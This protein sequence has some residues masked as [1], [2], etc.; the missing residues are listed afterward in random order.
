[1]QKDYKAGDFLKHEMSFATRTNDVPDGYISGIASSPS[2]DCYG[3]RVLPGAFDKSIRLRGFDGNKGGIKLLDHHDDKKPAIGVIRKLETV[4]KDL[5]I[6]AEFCLKS[7]R[8]KDMY[9]ETKFAGGMGFSVGF[10]LED[11]DFAEENGEDIF[12]IKEGDLREVSLVNFP[13]CSDA[14]MTF[15]KQ[16]AKLDDPALE[17]WLADMQ[18]AMLLLKDTDTV[19]ELEKALVAKGLAHGRNEAH[20]LFLVMKSCAHLLQDK[21]TPAGGDVKTA[22]PHPLLDASMLKPLLA[23]IARVQSML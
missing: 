12:L 1:M 8:V 15:I 7:S 4:G 20:K 10:R 23:D 9:E 19:S 22:P 6:E 3:H 5:R 14:Q 16:E 17:A 2:I 13:A 21:P 18:Q 11:F